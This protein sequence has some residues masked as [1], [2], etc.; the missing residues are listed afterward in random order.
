V[1]LHVITDRQRLSAAASEDVRR[2][3][4]LRQVAHAVD[5]GVDVVQIRERDLADRALLALVRD[6]V[7]IA[8]RS[9]R[10]CRVVVNDRVDVALASGA[11]GVHLRSD[12]PPPAAVRPIVPPGF[13]IGRSVHSPREASS[14]A[15]DVDYI[16]AGTLWP[17]LSK[18]GGG[19]LLGLGGLAET[20]HAVDRPVLAVGGITLDRVGDVARQGAAGIAA[21]GLFMASGESDEEA[22]RAVSLHE[23]VRATR[24][25]F[26]TLRGDS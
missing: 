9:P 8:R 26:D 16:V 25:R 12:S 13:L 10:V 19:A 22:C 15:R 14:V 23:I 11:D 3:C 2:T 17:T 18:T 1:I 20:V 5:A 6:I 24:A 7:E 4:L 21:I